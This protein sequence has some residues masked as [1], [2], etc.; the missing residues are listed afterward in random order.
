M[1]RK[2]FR[3]KAGGGGKGV[4]GGGAGPE[5]TGSVVV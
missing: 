4:E 3:R 5:N 1:N 2:T